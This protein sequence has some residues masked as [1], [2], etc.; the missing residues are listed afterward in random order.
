MRFSVEREKLIK[1]ITLATSVVEKKQTKPIL[2]NLLL[3]L[4]ENELSVT[5]SDMEI[6]IV[7]KAR[8][9]DGQSGA[10]TLPGK[11]LFD[12]CRALPDNAKIDLAVDNN[13]AI[14]RSGRS[15]FALSTLPAEDFPIV[16]DMADIATVELPQNVLRKCIEK[17]QFAMAQQDVRFYLNGLLLEVTPK[18]VRT[19]ATDGH[20]L[21]LYDHKISTKISENQQVIIPRKAVNELF[22]LLEDSSAPISISIA[23]THLRVRTDDIAFTTKLVDGRFPDYGRV[24]PQGGDK[25]INVDRETL[26]QAVAR[27]SILS[28]ERYR[29]LRVYLTSGS[30]KVI[31]NNPENEEAEEEVSVDYD[32]EKLEVGFNATYLGDALNAISESTVNLILADENSCCLIQG[33]GNSDGKFVVMPMR[34]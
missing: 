25:S 28:N 31:A 13:R 14:I 7:V 10:I 34:L 6:E 21:A 4:T 15:R 32:G 24:I 5:G 12:I 17:T 23:Q 2:S 30:L 19:V 8:I 3:K 27:A 22:R 26:R 29:S 11:K 16:E 18:H 33:E 9:E 1:P 20:R